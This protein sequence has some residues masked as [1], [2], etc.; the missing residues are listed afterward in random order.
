[1]IITEIAGLVKSSN[2]VDNLK[3]NTKKQCLG[4]SKEA[5]LTAPSPLAIDTHTDTLLRLR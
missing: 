5:D 2:D 3:D 1:M 4:K